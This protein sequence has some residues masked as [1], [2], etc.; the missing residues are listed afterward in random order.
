MLCEVMLGT[1]HRT[2]SC[3]SWQCVASMDLVRSLCHPFL[4]EEPACLLAV[5]R[6]STD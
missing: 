2:R 3:V 6:A 5:L 1:A 4:V